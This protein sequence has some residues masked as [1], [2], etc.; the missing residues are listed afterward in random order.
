MAQAFDE[1]VL[2]IEDETDPRI[3]RRRVLF[4]CEWPIAILIC[5]LLGVNLRSTVP[6]MLGR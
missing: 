5:Y 1:F 3:V 2:G 6:R 4:V